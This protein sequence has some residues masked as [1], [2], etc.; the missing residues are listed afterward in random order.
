MKKLI[1]KLKNK[2]EYIFSRFKYK[3]MCNV[4]CG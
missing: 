2:Y 4:S 1:K 3:I